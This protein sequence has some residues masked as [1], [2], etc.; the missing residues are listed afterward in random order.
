MYVYIYAYFC[1][2]RYVYIFQQIHVVISIYFSISVSFN[3]VI[4]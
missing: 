2:D 3:Y 4:S 1:E